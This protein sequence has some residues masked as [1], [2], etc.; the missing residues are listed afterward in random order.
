MHMGVV[1]DV[2]YVKQKMIADNEATMEEAATGRN[3]AKGGGD[4]WL[5]EGKWAPSKYWNMV[6]T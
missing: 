2:L 4:I 6:N 1:D 5:G 3:F